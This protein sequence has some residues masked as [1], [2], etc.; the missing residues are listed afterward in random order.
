MRAVTLALLFAMLF[1]L[2]IGRLTS[3]QQL[4]IRRA[5]SDWCAG[6]DT[7][8]NAAEET[9][10]RIA[11]WDTSQVTDMNALFE[12]KSTSNPAIG[13]GTHLSSLAC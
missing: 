10:G 11:D 8:R 6:G 4:T 9:Y 2:T 12:G 7:R 3:K 5:V 13:N 1:V